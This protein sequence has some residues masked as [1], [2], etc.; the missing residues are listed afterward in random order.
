MLVKRLLE[1][2]GRILGQAGEHLFVHARHAGGRFLQ[3]L[4]IGVFAHA[5]ENH[6]NAGFDFCSIHES[7]LSSGKSVRQLRKPQFCREGAGHS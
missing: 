1:M 7:F 6:A 5:F 4:A 3:A 2:H